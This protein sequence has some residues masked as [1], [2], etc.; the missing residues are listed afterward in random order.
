MAIRRF[1]A[2]YVDLPSVLNPKPV[3]QIFNVYDKWLEAKSGSMEKEEIHKELRM[4]V[5]C[6]VNKGNYWNL[7]KV[8]KL[9]DDNNKPYSCFMIWEEV[10]DVTPQTT[11]INGS[12]KL[13]EDAD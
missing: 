2:I 7:S 12:V 9:S 13:Q 1:T 3:T 4:A 10:H 8:T 5:S 11:D 6:F